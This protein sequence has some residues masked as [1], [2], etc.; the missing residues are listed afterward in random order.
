MVALSVEDP[1]ETPDPLL[2]AGQAAVR[3]ILEEISDESSGHGI[4]AAEVR[5][6]AQ[7]LHNPEKCAEMML[8]VLNFL[9]DSNTGLL[10]YRV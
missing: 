2:R 1:A 6:N 7:L 9:P 4:R 10:T 5:A 8:R 3:T